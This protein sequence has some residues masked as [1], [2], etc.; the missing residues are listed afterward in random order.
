MPYYFSAQESGRDKFTDALVFAGMAVLPA[1][2]WGARNWYLGGRL[3][4]L[5]PA[6]E[7]LERTLGL[8]VL[9]R[10]NDGV[11]YQVR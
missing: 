10:E 7:E 3:K 2:F 5:M 1:A 11:I 9:A 8:H 6:A 4:R